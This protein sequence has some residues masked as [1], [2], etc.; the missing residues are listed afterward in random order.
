MIF[1]STLKYEF[2][3]HRTVLLKVYSKYEQ[4]LMCIGPISL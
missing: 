4:K 3:E 2:E 1:S